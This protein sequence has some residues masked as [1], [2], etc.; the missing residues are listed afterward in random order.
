MP[1]P[2]KTVHPAKALTPVLAGR[3]PGAHTGLVQ[4]REAKVIT[5]QEVLQCRAP[6]RAKAWRIAGW[7]SC[8][9]GVRL[10]Y[11]FPWTTAK[12]CC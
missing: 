5:T 8:K 12:A 11:R 4:D 7:L 3:Q 1:L 10:T 6:R 9:Q 2:P